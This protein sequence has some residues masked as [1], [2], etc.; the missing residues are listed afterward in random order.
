MG[1]KKGL[2]LPEKWIWQTSRPRYRTGNC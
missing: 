2:K 1:P